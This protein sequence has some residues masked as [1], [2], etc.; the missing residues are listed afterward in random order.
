MT[1][2][3]CSDTERD[4]AVRAVED[5]R[6]G[7]LPTLREAIASPFAEA[8]ERSST[9][10]EM[11][12]TQSG[13][14]T[15]RVTL[16][17]VHRF[18]KPPREWDWWRLMELRPGESVRVVEEPSSDAGSEML[19]RS[20][21][22]AEMRRLK[23]EAERD[24]AIREWDELRQL[25]LRSEE[26]GT[27]LLAERNAALDAAD[28]LRARVAE[29][30]AASGG[31]SSAPPNGSQDAS[32]GGEGEPVAYLLDGPFEKRAFR[33]RDEVYAY[34]RY[35]PEIEKQSMQLVPLYR[36]PPQP[37]GW[38]TGEERKAMNWLLHN[39]SNCIVVGTDSYYREI[40][41]CLLARS[42]PPEVVLPEMV[43]AYD[44]MDMLK[45]TLAAAGVAVKEAT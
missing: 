35:L 15:D 2:A 45:E 43:I 44:D 39:H 23:V 30:D 22:A 41:K 17:C 25:W 12:G 33:T 3:W 18:G 28:A 29:L 20:L 21:V 19:R 11:G 42:T 1:H 9:V 7:R 4:E 6:T 27:R 16:E 13:I 36:S 26:S 10:S 38:L 31:N 8:A 37:R 40:I 32:G 24:T 34:T 5:K 14:R